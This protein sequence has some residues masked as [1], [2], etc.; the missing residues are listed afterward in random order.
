MSMLTVVIGAN[1]KK[2]WVQPRWRKRGGEFFFFFK[3]LLS[4]E[5]KNTK[6]IISQKLRI[7]QESHFC[8]KWA[9]VRSIPIFPVNLVT[10]EENRIFGRPKRPFWIPAAPKHDMMWYEILHPSLFSVHCAS[11]MSR[12]PLLMEGGGGLSVYPYSLVV[13]GPLCWK[14]I[15]I[16]YF[17][18]DNVIYNFRTGFAFQ[19]TSK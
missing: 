11:F 5:E 9:C 10:F 2:C 1:P 14:K 15:R 16:C 7:A 6:S 17:V 3:S 13:T 12:W 8:I 19:Y 18:V 4:P